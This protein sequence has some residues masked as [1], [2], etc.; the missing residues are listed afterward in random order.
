MKKSGALTEDENRKVHDEIQKL[1]KD[2][3]KK[4]DAVQEK[5][6]AEIMEV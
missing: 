5:K 3:E 6:L 2:C 4:L 1:L